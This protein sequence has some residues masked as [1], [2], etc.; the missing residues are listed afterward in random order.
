MSKTV[1][2]TTWFLLY[3]DASEP[4]AAPVGVARDI[5]DGAGKVGRQESLGRDGQWARTDF[6]L[7]QRR[8]STDIDAVEVDA[9]AAERVVVALRARL[10]PE[11]R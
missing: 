10:T 2:R 7:R 6:F 1:E 4:D 5:R 8:G 3:L 9:P 11:P